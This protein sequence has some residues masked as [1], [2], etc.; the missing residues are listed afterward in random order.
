MR[1]VCDIIFKRASV[2]CL[3]TVKRFQVLLSNTN[4]SI[5]TQLNG[6]KCFNLTLMILFNIN[7]LSP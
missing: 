5:C 2:H 3:H 7:H 1:T 6:F 4:I